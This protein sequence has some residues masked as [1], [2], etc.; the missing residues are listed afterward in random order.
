MGFDTGADPRRIQV[1]GNVGGMLPQAISV[2]RPFDLTQNAIFVS[3]ENDG[4][5][6]KG[7]YILFYA[8]GPDRI[9]YDADREIFAYESNL[10]SEKNFYFVT[11]GDN[12]GKRINAKP[13]VTGDFPLVQHYDDYVYHEIDE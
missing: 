2:S 9:Q 7:D 10:Y 11:V 5:F 12:N 8:E 13:N 3:G 1:V 4:S 6:D